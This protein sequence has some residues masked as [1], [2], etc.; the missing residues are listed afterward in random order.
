MSDINIKRKVTLKRKNETL[1]ETPRDKKPKKPI[2]FVI[3]GLV[4]IGGIFGLVKANQ[5]KSLD[6]VT[7]NVVA[8]N[9]GFRE[10]NDLVPNSK[11]DLNSNSG[12]GNTDQAFVG[13]DG[14]EQEPIAS[15]IENT[16]EIEPI[17]PSGIET[18][19][20]LND[21]P[22]SDGKKPMPAIVSGSV[23][24]KA[25]QVIRGDFGNGK[26]RRQVLGLEYTA[27]QTRVNE[28][29]QGGLVE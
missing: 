6:G 29:Y 26:D 5:H 12:N 15:S 27:I 2:W 21:I 18:S 8:D 22:N 20:T 7:N 14:A 28:I 3:I 9:P 19:A 10:E 4:V 25:K 16:V 23:E 24:E 13:Q 1:G 17:K 11:G